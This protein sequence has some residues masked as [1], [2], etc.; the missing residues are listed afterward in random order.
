MRLADVRLALVADELAVDVVRRD[1]LGPSRKPTPTRAPACGVGPVRISLYCEPP[2]HAAVAT[3]ALRT[4]KIVILLCSRHAWPLI[5]LTSCSQP[6]SSMKPELYP[7]APIR[8][9]AR[10]RLGFALPPLLAPRLP[11]LQLRCSSCNR[12]SKRTA[13]RGQDEIRFF[14]FVCIYNNKTTTA[15]RVASSIGPAQAFQ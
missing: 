9:R 4:S 14:H 6:S 2:L 3:C 7:A 5:M 10:S 15:T 1:G 13:P 12:S 8:R 11:V